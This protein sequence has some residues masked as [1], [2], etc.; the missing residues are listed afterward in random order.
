[1]WQQFHLIHCFINVER[2]SESR[3]EN[4]TSKLYIINYEEE[5]V[6]FTVAGALG[7][8]NFFPRHFTTI[9]LKLSDFM[10]ISDNWG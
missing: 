2:W 5:S 3:E 8:N 6:K 9:R 4:K 7:E 10:F 1:M